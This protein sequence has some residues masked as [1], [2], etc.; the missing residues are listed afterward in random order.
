MDGDPG[1]SYPPPPQP[2]R[3][4]C[5]DFPITLTISHMPLV[6]FWCWIYAQSYF[7]IIL[8]YPDPNSVYTIMGATIWPVTTK[9]DLQIYGVYR[10]GNGNARPLWFMGSLGNYYPIMV[11]TTSW[12]STGSNYL[13]MDSSTGWYTATTEGGKICT[14]SQYFWRNFCMSVYSSCG[15]WCTT[16]FNVFSTFPHLLTFYPNNVA[17]VSASHM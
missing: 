8:W 9:E 10:V 11:L 5:K 14:K 12:N 7:S 2:E 13:N 16:N 6:V 17:C 4:R 1:A 3:L 15:W